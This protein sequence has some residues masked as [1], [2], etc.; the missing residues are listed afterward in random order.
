[1]SF[2]NLPTD[3]RTLYATLYGYADGAWSIQDSG[4]YT[5][6][7]ITNAQITSPPKGSAFSSDTVTFTWTAETGATSYQMWLGSAPGQYDLGVG[8]VSVL[9][10]TIGDLP[11]NCSQVYATLYGYSGEAWTVQDTAQYTSAGCP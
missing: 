9:V 3:G 1:M 11:T 6:A 8:G 7:A 4:Q 10:V 2:S 5:A